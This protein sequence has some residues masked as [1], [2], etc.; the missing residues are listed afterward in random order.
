MYLR[1]VHIK[2]IRSLKEIRWDVPRTKTAG[3]HVIIGDNGSGKSTFLRSIALALIGPRDVAGLRLSWE[4]WLRRDQ[5]EGSIKIGIDWDKR[6]DRFPDEESIPR[7]C[8]LRLGIMLT[9]TSAE[10]LPNLN[11]LLVGFEVLPAVQ[12]TDLDPEAEPNRHVWGL[13]EG[14]SCCGYGPFRRFTGGDQEF[15]R[16][17]LRLPK[18]ARYLSLFDERLAL[19]DCLEWLQNLKFQQT[20]GRSGGRTS[21]RSGRELLPAIFSSLTSRTSYLTRYSSRTS[22]R[23]SVLFVQRQPDGG[24]DRGPERWLSF[25]PEHDVRAHPATGGSPMDQVAFSIRTTRRRSSAPESS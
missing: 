4:D 2:N 3:W 19:T 6:F 11:R 15:S 13:A 21:E 14:W 17:S 9:R 5:S 23:T 22:R 25:D 1:E 10:N 8:P 7:Q 24:P 12:L 20:R 18:L 16:I